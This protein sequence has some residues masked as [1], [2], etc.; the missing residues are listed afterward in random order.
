METWSLTT[1][2]WVVL[3]TNWPFYSHL[4]MDF[5]E[6]SLWVFPQSFNGRIRGKVS[7]AL[8]RWGLG[9][10]TSSTVPKFSIYFKSMVQLSFLY[11]TDPE[12]CS[13][14]R[15]IFSEPAV[16]KV[17]VF[18]TEL[19][20]NLHFPKNHIRA[21]WVTDVDKRCSCRRHDLVTLNSSWRSSNAVVNIL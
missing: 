10:F 11:G 7:L 12:H 18:A 14:R 20:K 5:E 15:S 8:P 21:D 6:L 4:C 13:R 3:S 16:H 1:C 17:R 2:N 19:A 9:K